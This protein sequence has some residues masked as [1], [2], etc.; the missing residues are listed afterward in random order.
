[1]KDLIQKSSELCYQ[2]KHYDITGFTSQMGF[3][4]SPTKQRELYYAI[5]WP[6]YVLLGSVL[7]SDSGD[8]LV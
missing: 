8:P 7:P 1:M 6:R 3:G 2:A 4:F 5:H